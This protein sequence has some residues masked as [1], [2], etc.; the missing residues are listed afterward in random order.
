LP[1]LSS[2]PENESALCVYVLAV[3]LYA[4]ADG[5]DQL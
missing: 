5:M 3:S 4:Y 2:V 1:A